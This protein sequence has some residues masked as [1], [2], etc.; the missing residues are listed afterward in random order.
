MLSL[1]TGRQTSRAFPG[2][3]LGDRDALLDPLK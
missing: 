3:T 2:V 1:L